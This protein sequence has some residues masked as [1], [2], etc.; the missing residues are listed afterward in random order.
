[1][2]ELADPLLKLE[3]FQ[4]VAAAAQERQTLALAQL[5]SFEFGALGHRSEL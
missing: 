4:V 1:M 2:V 5:V 3:I